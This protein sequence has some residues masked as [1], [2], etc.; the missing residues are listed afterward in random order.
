MKI[1]HSEL[2]LCR[3]NPS[4]WAAARIASASTKPRFGMTYDRALKLAIHK[5]HNSDAQAALQYLEDLITRHQQKKK[6]LNKLRV[7]GI[8][9]QLSYYIKWWKACDAPMID[10]SFTLRDS[11]AGTLALGGKI[12][13]LDLTAKGYRAVLFGIAKIDWKQELRMPLIQWIISEM[14]GRPIS[15]ISVGFQ[16]VDGTNLDTHT[17]SGRRG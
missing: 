5:F 4:Q 17:Y 8:R 12:S 11:G 15:E 9:K 14:Y 13:R 1:S 3:S 10:S 7:E 16:K 6:L 2:E